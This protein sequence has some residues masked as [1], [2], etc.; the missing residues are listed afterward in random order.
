MLDLNCYEEIGKTPE[1]EEK[2]D[3]SC[4]EEV[5]TTPES[6]LKYFKAEEKKNMPFSQEEFDA[7]FARNLAKVKRKIV[8]DDE[9]NGKNKKKRN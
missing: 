8:F 1:T 6:G 3:L 9:K 4:Y 5:E 2:M 7:A